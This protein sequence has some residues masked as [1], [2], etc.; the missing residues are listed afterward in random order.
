MNVRSLPARIVYTVIALPLAGA[1]GFYSCM[2]LLPEF[3]V[4]H[5]QIDP[6]MDGS[7]IFKIAIC[8]GGALAFAASL[9]VLTL[10]W[11]RHRKRGG[12]PWRIGLSCVVVVLA[13]LLFADQGFNLIYDFVFAAWLTYILAFTFVRY[14][15]IDQARRS[16]SSSSARY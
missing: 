5:P 3:T 15:V 12:R 6:N 9:F 10:P 2:R 4:N 11:I 8:V 14:G 1:A 13:S 7:G 16:S